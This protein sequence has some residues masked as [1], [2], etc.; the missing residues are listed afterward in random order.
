MHNKR[1]IY[2][3]NVCK[4]DLCDCLR[5]NAKGIHLC[6]SRWASK[7]GGAY[8]RAGL[9]PS[10]LISGIVYSLANGWAYIWGSLKLGGGALINKVGFYGIKE[11]NKYF[12][13]VHCIHQYLQ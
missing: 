6:S 11:V 1:R 10:R 13:T 7:W 8:I 5:R 4:T 9:Y 12:L 3:K 2:F